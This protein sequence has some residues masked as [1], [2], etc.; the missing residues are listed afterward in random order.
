[1]H[2]LLYDG[3]ITLSCIS[4]C[5][6]LMHPPGS[7]PVGFQASMP[8]THKG[9][10]GGE[11]NARIILPT[12]TDNLHYTFFPLLSCAAMSIFLSLKDKLLPKPSDKNFSPQMLRSSQYFGISCSIWPHLSSM[13]TL[14]RQT[15]TSTM[16]H[17]NFP[18]NFFC[19]ISPG[20]I[21]DNNPHRKLKLKTTTLE[22]E[23]TELFWKVAV[24]RV[25]LYHSSKLCPVLELGW[26]E[27]SLPLNALA[28]PSQVSRVHHCQ[29]FILLN[30]TKFKFTFI[31]GNPQ[32]SQCTSVPNKAVFPFEKKI[33]SASLLPTQK[34][35]DGTG[36]TAPIQP[37]DV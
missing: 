28:C 11:A 15:S 27:G 18:P 20:V 12:S 37:S 32:S 17:I 10:N 3:S 13:F 16:G 19:T 36:Q 14:F 35:C 9:S 23:K 26:V 7:L 24:K 33:S 25:V 6:E 5:Q 2:P 21:S 30:H 31:I 29:S 34:G 22:E 4:A 1:M 8:T